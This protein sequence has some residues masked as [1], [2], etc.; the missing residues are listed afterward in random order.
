M[1]YICFLERCVGTL[2]DL[3]VTLVHYA[4]DR[5]LGRASCSHDY[6]VVEFKTLCAL[7]Y[8]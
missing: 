8:V 1:A 7:K 5:I 4:L 3:Q 6:L 2:L